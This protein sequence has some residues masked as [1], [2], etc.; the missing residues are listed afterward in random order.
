MAT[1][2][3]I[4]LGNMGG[5]MARNLIKAGHKLKAFDVVQANVDAAAKAGSA[6]VTSAADAAQGVD[7]VVTMLPAGQHV[8]DVYMGAGKV[9]ASAAKGTR[10]A[11]SAPRLRP[12]ATRWS[13]R[14]SPAARSGRRTPP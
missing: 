9:I 14:P 6:A 10:P 5:P 4:G 3:V 8:R 11:P 2:G 7:I 12:P 1:I 13:T